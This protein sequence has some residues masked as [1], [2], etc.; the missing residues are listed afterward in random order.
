MSEMLLGIY[1]S[2][3]NLHCGYVV[4]ANLFETLRCKLQHNLT[5]IRFGSFL[6]FISE[7]NN[8]HL[9]IR[10]N[11]HNINKRTHKCQQQ[12]PGGRLLKL[13]EWTWGNVK[14]SGKTGEKNMSVPENDH[15][16]E[17]GPRKEKAPSFLFIY[18]PHINSGT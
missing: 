9:R 3:G 11:N 13:S 18:V 4:A 5:H 15:N 12:I 8:H 2:A 10:N 1:A 16:K 7:R 6:L 17:R 14:R